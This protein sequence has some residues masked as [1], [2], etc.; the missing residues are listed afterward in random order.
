MLPPAWRNGLTRRSPKP[1]IPGSSPGVGRRVLL[2][3]VL[4]YPHLDWELGNLCFV[5]VLGHVILQC[6]G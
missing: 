3:S 5:S 6:F 1:K 4:G 2:Q